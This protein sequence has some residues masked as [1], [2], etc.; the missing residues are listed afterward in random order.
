MT[1]A[2][3]VPADQARVGD[4]IGYTKNGQ[5]IYLPGGGARDGQVVVDDGDDEPDDFG[6]SD[7]EDDDPED[8]DPEDEPPARQ[9][10]KPTYKDLQD[11]IARLQGS[12]RRNNKELGNRRKLGQWAEKHG[13]T[14]LDAW[15]EGLGVDKETG[16]PKQSAAPSTTPE[17]VQQP[18][19]QSPAEPAAPAATG[20][21]DAEVERRVNLRL[22]QEGARNEEENTTLRS[23]L[24]QSRLE[25]EL[26]GLGFRGKF[27]VALR[28]VDLDSIEV[29][30]EGKVTGADAAA[31]SLKEEIPEWFRQPTN[32]GR[33][34]SGGEDVDGGGR[35][36]P[37]APQRETWDRQILKRIRGGV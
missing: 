14:D 15:L 1:Q 16:K 12:V 4:L 9:P 24:A 10:R 29:D 30:G 37:T 3:P 20:Y 2:T 21:D 11:Q 27:E 22:E 31:Q 35:Q 32:G 36:R 34:R 13:I 5:P 33:G 7:D 26:R 28:V 25:S 6:G 23:A 19:Q 17:P 8:D 18:A